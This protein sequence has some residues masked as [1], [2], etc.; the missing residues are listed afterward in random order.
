[1]REHY[2]DRKIQ[3]TSCNPPLE[4]NAYRDIALPTRKN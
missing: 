1:M 4:G 3:G 2:D